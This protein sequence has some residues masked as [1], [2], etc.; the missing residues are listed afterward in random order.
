M[1]D[2]TWLQTQGIS[3]SSIRDYVD[4]GW[5]ERIG[6]RVY[7][8]P[9]QLTKASLRWDVVV[10]S[11]QQIMH[12]P[13]HVGGRTAVELSGYAHYVEAGDT[14]RVYLYGS[15]LPPGLQSCRYPLSL[16]PALRDCLQTRV[17]AL[18][19][20]VTICVLAKHQDR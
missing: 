4:R 16:R 11:L 9:S 6:P 17:A 12:T 13:L 18:K 10:L 14:S 2:S 19:R 3:R 8:R 15:G 5:L 1:A 20:S 7:R